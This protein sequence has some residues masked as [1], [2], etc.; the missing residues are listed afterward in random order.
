MY[1]MNC[2]HLFCDLLTFL[3]ALYSYLRKRTKGILQVKERFSDILWWYIFLLAYIGKLLVCN[4]L[5][6]HEVIFLN[7]RWS[8]ALSLCLLTFT[9]AC[10]CPCSRFYA[11]I[12]LPTHCLEYAFFHNRT[13]GSKWHVSKLF[14]QGVMELSM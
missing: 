8:L 6:N 3:I 1:F 12:S 4:F 10:T 5:F 2:F 11:T 13:T 14:T 9:H 7:A